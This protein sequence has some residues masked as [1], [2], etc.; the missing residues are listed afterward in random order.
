[1]DRWCIMWTSVLYCYVR[2]QWPIL[3]VGFNS[4]L[5]GGNLGKC[6]KN[7]ALI[8]GFRFHINVFFFFIFRIT[9]YSQSLIAIE[10]SKSGQ[11]YIRSHTKYNLTVSYVD[12]IIRLLAISKNKFQNSENSKDRITDWFILH[13]FRLPL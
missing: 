1:M 8:I 13:T 12:I 10:E 11:I 9:N 5:I 7:F 4:I 6:V 3:H 2:E